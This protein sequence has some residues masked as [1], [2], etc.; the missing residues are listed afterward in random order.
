MDENDQE[1]EFQDKQQKKSFWN[2][3]RT[4][5]GKALSA[6]VIV[7]IL[8]FML[9]TFG[10]GLFLGKKVFVENNNKEKEPVNNENTETNT[11]APT[12]EKAHTSF[13]EKNGEYELNYS[14]SV[15]DNNFGLSMYLL[16]DQ[17]SVRIT[18]SKY[19]IKDIYQVDI[20]EDFTKV[21][22]FDK[23]VL[24][25]FF[26]GFGQGVGAETIVFLMEDGTI[27]YIPFYKEISKTNWSS[28]SESEKMNSYGTVN[29]VTNV[30]GLYKLSVDSEFSGYISIGAT[31]KDGS[32]YNLFEF[33]EFKN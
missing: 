10:L 26:G 16:S 14:Q 15:Y 23:K 20:K 28:L 6:W 29:G 32:F 7:M 33:D 4:I 1:F 11:P 12:S 17:K 5:K 19:A 21:L 31:R 3:K 24:Q 30:I 8:V 2:N 18:V 25:I 13:V 9:F 22:N 27:E